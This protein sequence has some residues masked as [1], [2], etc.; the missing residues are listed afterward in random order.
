LLKLGK[1][2]TW[3]LDSIR[4]HFTIHSQYPTDEIL[5]QIQLKRAIRNHLVNNIISVGPDNKMT[6]DNENMKMLQTIDKDIIQ[7]MK[8]KNETSHMIGFSD[9]LDF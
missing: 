8:L 4:Q 6:F 2:V 1:D 9:Q 3:S 7:L 5:T